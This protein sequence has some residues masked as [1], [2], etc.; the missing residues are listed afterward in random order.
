VIKIM[1]DRNAG[2]RQGLSLHQQ[3]RLADA[4]YIYQ[5]VLQ[6]RPDH[7][8]ALHLLGVIALQTRRAD[9]GI[10]LIRQAIVQNPVNAAAHCNLGNG[11]RTLNRLDEAVAS[12]DQAIALQPAF[13]EA[14][15][16]RGNALRML[17]R[18]A[19]A[20]ESY[21]KAI[22][23]TP[24]HAEAY[25][26]RGNGL[27]ALN[28]LEEAVASYDMAITLN[29]KYAEA[30]SNRGIALRGLKRHAE[31]VASY[32]EAIALKPDFA[33]VFSNRGIV[34]R[35]LKLYPEA[36]ASYD[37][38][39]ALNPDFAEAYTNRAIVLRDL[40]RLE[41]ALASFDTAIALKPDYA[42]ACYSRAITL[43]DMNRPEE[44]VASYDHAIALT[45]DHAE[46]HYGRGSVLLDLNRL[47]EAVASYDSAIALKPD[48]AAAFYSRGIALPDLN[49]PEEAIISY[50]GAIALKSDF[51]EAYSNRGIVL[52]Q[53]NREAEAMASYDK[54]IALKPD[55]VEA[56]LNLAAALKVQ[57]R[58]DEATA[59]YERALSL[60]PDL[61]EVR[62]HL[63]MAQ[64]PILYQDPSEIDQRR[65]AYRER[66]LELRD[67]VQHRRVSGDLAAAVGS[68]QP[69]FLAYQAY[70]DRELQSLYG[71]LVC[72]MI[73]ERYPATL[74]PSPPG[75][76][77]QVRVGFVSG[78][79]RRHSNWKIPIKGWLSQLD[80]RRFEI[81]GYHTGKTRDDETKAAASFCDH[82]VQGPLPADRWR[83]LVLANQPHI[84]IYPEV[85]MDPV[86]A[87]LA[88]QRLAP[89]QCVSWGH[90]NT[91]GYPTIDYFLSSELMEPSNAQQ[92]YTERL[93]RLPNL[94]I[95]YD[96]PE[97]SRSTGDRAAFGLRS[98]AVLY[99]CGQSAMKYLPQFDGVFPR[100]AGDVSDC[101]FVFIVNE[102]SPC[103]TRQFQDRLHRAF[104][105]FGL[106]ARDH[107]VFLPRLGPELFVAAIGQ[108]DIVLDSIGWSGCN[109]TLEGLAHDVPIV[110]LTGSLMRGR[111]TTGILTMM[112]VTETI[113]GTVDEYVSLAIRLARDIAWRTSLRR[114]MSEEKYRVFRDRDC[115]SA[116]EDFLWR[117]ARE[118]PI[119]AR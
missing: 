96:P 18:D 23:L 43:R 46:A 75:P 85:G 101:Q 116:L 9:Q 76:R 52:A 57:G 95:Y 115:I 56:H 59:G 98:S 112:G 61:A 81:F 39:I 42:A 74:L 63:C 51:A 45:P 54:A 47:E 73:A 27:R 24:D 16:N 117:V 71:D 103:V 107:C 11:L 20:V 90:P 6:Q 3:G 53:L 105:A 17:N 49:R 5:Q 78:F 99:W 68:A 66:L 10:D 38:A 14:W 19:E 48:D 82:F 79:F 93:I 60:R 25:Y 50:D 12:Y 83:E 118:P 22:T 65:A 102:N 35:E 26:S 70:N 114:R 15:C 55:L 2:F 104:A 80:R 32:D 77:E 113:A 31:A 64:L 37:T 1:T 72:R 92:H 67:D 29:P 91:T 100:I 110:T 58:L 69:F 111:H 106:N 30:Y 34:Q 7:H 13:A 89:V 21:D 97:T 41:E 36:V 33:E 44:A 28:R 87:W 84:L 40:N 94:S 119:T 8:E 88:A 109:S 108:C 86:S 4:E 62:L